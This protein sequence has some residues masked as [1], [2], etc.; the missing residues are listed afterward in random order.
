MKSLKSTFV[1][2]LIILV[3][4]TSISMAQQRGHGK[5]HNKGFGQAH[6]FSGRFFNQSPEM[7]KLYETKITPL[8][9]QMQ[10]KL[11]AEIAKEDK[12]KLSVLKTKLDAKIKE[13]QDHRDK[14]EK[15][16][17]ELYCANENADRF[18]I[19][20]QLRKEFPASER[21]RMEL[22]TELRP[23]ADKYSASFD[24]LKLEFAS[25]IESI[26]QE[27]A[28]LHKSKFQ[29][30]RQGRKA[31]KGKGKSMRMKQGRSHNSFLG[32]HRMFAMLLVWDENRSF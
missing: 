21:N 9:K 25:E 20:E 4:A 6:S 8:L 18:E 28:K 5:G 12:D 2:A 29:E 19:R 16:F 14:K 13:R 17:R 24:K 11:Y 23:I 32:N 30:H 7:K 31:G 26:K 1:L 22:M 10:A 3:G 27:I 15:K